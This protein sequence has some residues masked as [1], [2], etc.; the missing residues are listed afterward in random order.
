MPLLGLQ[1]ANN[2][3]LFVHRLASDVYSG[4]IHLAD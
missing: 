2:I 4:W 3:F 1:A